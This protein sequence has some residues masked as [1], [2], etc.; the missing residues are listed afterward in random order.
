MENTKNEKQCAI[1]DVMCGAFVS[2]NPD[3]GYGQKQ[4]EKVY[5]VIEIWNGS[6]T[7]TVRVDSKS[8]MTKPVLD[9]VHHT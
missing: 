5:E 4:C 2:L 8:C 7:I 3:K 6:E 1:H 9:F